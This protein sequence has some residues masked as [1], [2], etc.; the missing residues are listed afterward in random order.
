MIIYYRRPSI[1]HSKHSLKLFN[2]CNNHYSNVGHSLLSRKSTIPCFYIQYKNHK[3]VEFLIQSDSH[4]SIKKIR[5]ERHL[6]GS[7]RSRM[8]KN[9]G[10]YQASQGTEHVHSTQLY[11]FFIKQYLA[12]GISYGKWKER[13]AFKDIR[14]KS[15]YIA[16]DRIGSCM[17]KVP[18]IN[19][20]YKGR[21][22]SVPSTGQS[23]ANKSFNFFISTTFR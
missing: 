4:V 11:F 9:L 22:F 13:V 20:G 15:I 3:K 17:K 16:S 12:D 18:H 2:Q 10:E 8:P 21:H 19:C 14:F 5:C 6:K 1:I 23:I 7:T